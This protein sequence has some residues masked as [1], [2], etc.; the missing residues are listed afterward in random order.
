MNRLPSGNFIVLRGA[1]GF[2]PKRT[3]KADHSH[4][5]VKYPKGRE[6]VR[7]KVACLHDGK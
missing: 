4:M 1:S 5:G 6:T 2:R 3:S 7:V